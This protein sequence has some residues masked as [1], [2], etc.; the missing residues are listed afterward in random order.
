MPHLFCSPSFQPGGAMR[1][2]PT[3]SLIRTLSEL[4]TNALAQAP[5][6]SS[7]PRA[8][9]HRIGP[10]L[11]RVIGHSNLDARAWPVGNDTGGG[12]TVSARDQVLAAVARH[13]AGRSPGLPPDAL[14]SL[15]G[16]S[17]TVLGEAV[18]ALVQSGELIRDAWLVRLPSTGDLLPHQPS[19]EASPEPVHLDSERR[20]I[21]DRRRLGERRLFER[22]HEAG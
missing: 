11:A 18:S 10:E 16:L 6:L 12:Q 9:A 17:L 1:G 4:L 13:P 5:H 2:D 7:D 3:N 19:V 21:G 20:A 8:L 15:T 14:S 22:R